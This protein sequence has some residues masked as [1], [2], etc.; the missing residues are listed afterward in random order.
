MDWPV[1]DQPFC[2]VRHSAS[3]TLATGVSQFLDFD[4]E[5]EDTD[6]M[7]YTSSANLSGTVTKTAASASLVGVG[8][9]FT[10]ELTVGQVISVPGTAAEKRTVIAIA[11]D[12]HLTVASA[13]VNSASGQVAKRVNG[14]ITI[15]TPGVYQFSMFLRFAANNIGLREG[16]I[17]RNDSAIRDVF[18]SVNATGSGDPTSFGLTLP[19]VRCAQWDFIECKAFQNSGGNLAVES[20]DPYSPT[21]SALRVR[22]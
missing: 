22:S 12:T 17:Y 6:E 5:V 21:M 9:A 4:T 8:T 15:R 7:H 18:S 13:F 20:T 3:Q 10:T 1:N 11:D 2:R 19:P 16:D 14:A